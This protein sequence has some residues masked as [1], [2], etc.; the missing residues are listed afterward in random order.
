MTLVKNHLILKEDKFL[1]SW[2]SHTCCTEGVIQG[3]VADY[4]SWLL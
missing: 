3:H 4:W 2:T 1:K